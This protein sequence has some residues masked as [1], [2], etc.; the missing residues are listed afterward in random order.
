[1]SMSQD[2]I[3]TTTDSIPG[4]RIVKILGIVVGSTCRARHIGRDIL[5]TLRGVIGGEVKEYTELVEEARKIALARMIEK[6]KQMGANAVIGVRFGTTMIT[7][8][9][10]EIYAYGTAV[11]V[12]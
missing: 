11:I 7:Q 2:I 10:A 9:I 4:K 8:G 5:A 6:A 12:E 3:V 1:M